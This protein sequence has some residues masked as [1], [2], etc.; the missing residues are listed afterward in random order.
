MAEPRDDLESLMYTLA[1][2][3]SN[4][5][6]WYDPCDDSVPEDAATMC[7]IKQE[8]T[9]HDIFPDMG[10]EIKFIM[11]YIWNLDVDDK[12]DYARMREILLRGADSTLSHSPLL[13]EN[14]RYNS[15]AYT[16]RKESKYKLNFEEIFKELSGSGYV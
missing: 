4:E 5:L 7:H 15:S 10:P 9:A 13:D 8:S 6:P 11:E 12:P 2:L 1:F 3:R 16:C 14:L